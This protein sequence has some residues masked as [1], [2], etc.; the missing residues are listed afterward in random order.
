[1]VT[2]SQLRIY[3][4]KSCAGIRIS[5]ATLSA[6][7]L[8][9][10]RR[11]MLIDQDGQFLSQRTHPRMALICVAISDDHV[12]VS[13]SGAP[14]L[15]F[16]ADS[17]RGAQAFTVGIWRDSVRV[18]D[19]GDA[20]GLW[21]SEFLNCKC[22]LVVLDDTYRRVVDADWTQGTSAS[23]TLTDGFPLLVIGENSLNDLNARLLQKGAP[24]ADIRQF[25]PNV[26]LRGLEPY[27]EDYLD[28]L[29][30]LANEKEVIIKLVKPCT[31]CVITTVNQDLGERNSGWNNEPLETLCTY[32]SNAR[33]GGAISFGQNAIVLSEDS[34]VIHEGIEVEVNYAFND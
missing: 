27:E 2:V 12:A 13:A 22:R 33:V 29:T 28:T 19:C 11:W 10:D 34:T 6:Y 8:E 23:T 25:R 1:M 21:F 7:G 4:I 24:Q 17:S 26:V 20:P 18:Y 31:R 5:Q 14:P 32:R 30:M 16:F 9:S 3:P 15:V